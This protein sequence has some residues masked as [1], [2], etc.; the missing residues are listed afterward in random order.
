MSY[1]K[2]YNERIAKQDAGGAALK[3]LWDAWARACRAEEKAKEAYYDAAAAS[4]VQLC[5]SC[6]KPMPG[7]DTSREC[8]GCHLPWGW[9]TP[10]GRK[11]REREELDAKIAALQAQR[12]KL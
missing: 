10:E 5:D 3:P 8:D 11:A 4:G 6:S 1:M 2:A 7:Y 9:D 12:A